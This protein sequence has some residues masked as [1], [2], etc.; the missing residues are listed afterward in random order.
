MFFIKTLMHA[1]QIYTN[2][3][4]LKLN[5]HIGPSCI[6]K[7]TFYGYKNKYFHFF[8]KNIVSTVRKITT[9]PPPENI[10]V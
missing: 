5:L 3:M 9:P 7:K 1:D 10:L 4:E 8:Y 2:L 6:V